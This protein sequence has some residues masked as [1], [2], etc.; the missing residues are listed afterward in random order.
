MVTSKT[1]AVP[2]SSWRLVPPGR[3]AFSLLE[4]VLVLAIIAVVAVIAAPRYANALCRYRADMAARRIAADLEAARS[5]AKSTSASQAVT[6]D[7]ASDAYELVGREDP[8]R[9]GAPYAV[10]VSAA[11]YHADL[12]GALFGGG[13]TVTFDGFGVPDSGGDVGVQVG[14]H[15]RTVRVDPDTG[16]ITIE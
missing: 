6:F 16:K 14:D 1:K 3:A 10:I 12:S 2:S 4:V 11:P 9:Q 7:T 5:W 13:A 8:D 15:A